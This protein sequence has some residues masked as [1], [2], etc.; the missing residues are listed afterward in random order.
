M[1]GRKLC[2]QSLQ[3]ES[4]CSMQVLK[5]SYSRVRLKASVLHELIKWLVCLSTCWANVATAV[6]SYPFLFMRELYI[7]TDRIFRCTL[8]EFTVSLSPNFLWF[9]SWNPNLSS[10]HVSTL[11]F[12]YQLLLPFP[13]NTDVVIRMT[14]I[15]LQAIC[16]IF[17]VQRYCLKGSKDFEQTGLAG[18]LSASPP[19]WAQ[20]PVFVNRALQG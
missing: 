1:K 19:L 3:R 11:L 6:A 10:C 18:G 7:T 16:P 5:S 8:T 13:L 20:Q 12:W 14:C 9:P 15:L 17:N 4:L 2:C